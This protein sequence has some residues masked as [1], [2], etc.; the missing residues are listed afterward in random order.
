[1][2]TIA[3]S[4]LDGKNRLTVPKLVR[5]RLKLTPTTEDEPGDLVRFVEDEQ[6]RIY[7]KKLD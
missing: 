7:I 5:D 4:R 6:G 1:M 3:T 2:K